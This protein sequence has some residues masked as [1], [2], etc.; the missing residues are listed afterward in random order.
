MKVRQANIP[1]ATPVPLSHAVVDV[2]I[3]FVLAA[4][5]EKLHKSA[6]FDDQDVSDMLARLYE[7][8]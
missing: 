1:T 5:I 4:L 8:E 2:G 6:T 3:G 7:V